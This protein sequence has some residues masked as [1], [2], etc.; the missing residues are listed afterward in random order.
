M[1]EY[2]V[3]STKGEDMSKAR[4][5][6][7]RIMKLEGDKAKEVILKEFS[8]AN[9]LAIFCNHEWNKNT[10]SQTVDGI[11]VWSE[12]YYQCN[13]CNSRYW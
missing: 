1:E 7:T 4:D 5:E 10:N 6:M 9:N 13:K 2:K 12:E 11:P 8:D 3:I